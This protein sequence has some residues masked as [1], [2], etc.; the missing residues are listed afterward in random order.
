MQS[1]KISIIVP[2]YNAARFLSN[3][4]DSILAQTHANIEVIVVNDGST[5]VTAS[6]L[7]EYALKDARIKAI[8]KENGGVT[9]ARFCGIAA[10]SGEWIGFVDGDDAI[11]PDMYERLLANAEKYGAQISHCGYR[12]ILESGQER[13]F[14]NT[15]RLA[16]Q[17]TL[18]ALKELLDG[19][20]IEPGLWNKLFHKNLFHSLLHGDEMDLTIKNNED[21]LMN[22]ILFMQAKKA[23]Y[24][25]FCPYR[26]YA[27]KGSATSRTLAEYKIFDPIRV[28]ERLLTIV[29]P[30]MEDDAKKACAMTCINIYNDLFSSRGS[31]ARILQLGVREK[32]L[33]HY[34]RVSYVSKKYRCMAWLIRYAPWLYRVIYAVYALTLRKS[35]YE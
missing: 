21:L 34:H 2:A 30:E 15:G 31:K 27:R 9:S 23:V 13:C 18:T 26:Y 35:R 3:C 28:K 4:L 22:V 32:I 19:S 10:A 6:I 1:Q 17:D 33:E 8:H 24:E 20:F 12:L 25:D 7:D 14:Y 29:P 5:D 16:E 11:H